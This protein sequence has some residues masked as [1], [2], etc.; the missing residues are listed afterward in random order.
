LPLI[1]LILHVLTRAIRAAFVLPSVN[2][3]PP[4]TRWSKNFGNPQQTFA[5][6]PLNLI[7]NAK[8]A[9]QLLTTAELLKIC[10]SAA[11]LTD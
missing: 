4:V 10:F 3:G 8:Q 9:L 2:H 7:F 1:K 6:T 11:N 5:A